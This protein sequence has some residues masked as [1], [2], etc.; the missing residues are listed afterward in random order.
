MEHC[1]LTDFKAFD[2]EET[3]QTLRYTIKF[4][5]HSQRFS[6]WRASLEQHAD[7][8]QTHQYALRGLLLNGKWNVPEEGLLYWESPAPEGSVPVF[9]L[10]DY[11]LSANYP[12]TPKEK[13]EFL[14]LALYHRQQWDGAR[15][16]T[17]EDHELENYGAY[18]MVNPA[19]Y[20]F[21]LATLTQQGLLE[22]VELNMGHCLTYAG[23]N[24]VIELQENG[25]H[26]DRCFIAMSFSPEERIRQI[27]QA[28]KEACVATGFVPILIDEV[29]FD[30]DITIN[31]AMIAEIKRCKFCIADFTQ[32]KDGV[33]FEA[34][35]ASGRGLKV[36]YTCHRDDRKGRHFDVRAFP[37]LYYEDMATLKSGLINKIKAWIV[38]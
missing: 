1:P 27:R 10:V 25:L 26:S 4:R 22:T 32:Q 33:Y 34:G 30:S 13:L 37:F 20:Q 36:L 8:L 29:Y 3:D 21:Y 5:D 31:D 12:R 7:Y 9:D 28:I 17:S 14:F 23:L 2:V 24:R 15:I 16:R 19:E 35:F 6:L 11:L 38:D 18:Y